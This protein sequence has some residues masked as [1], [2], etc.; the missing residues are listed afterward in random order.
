MTDSILDVTTGVTYA[1]VSDAIAL[2]G[3]GDLIQIPAGTYAEDFPKIR[4]D[5]TLEGVGGLAH[6]EPV[7][8]QPPSN[9]EAI[10]VTDAN[11]TLEKLELSGATV[12]DGNGA[13]VREETGNLTVV[14]SW[15]HDNQDGILTSGS[16]AGA[17]LTI[18]KTE[19]S[20]N[21]AGDGKT[22]N[23]YVGQIA[24]LDIT[25]SYFTAANG[26]HEI[27]SRADTTIIED[28]RIQDG[29]TADTSYSVDLPNGGV[30]T[31][32]NNV[33]EKGPNSPDDAIIHYGGEVSTVDAGSSLVISNNTVINDKGAAP[34]VF[35][36]AVFA[37]GGTI[38]APSISG[39]TF[40]GLTADQLLA[41]PDFGDTQSGAPYAATNNFLPIGDEPALDTSP[42][43]IPCFRAGTR[44]A[45]AGGPVAVEALRA[46]DRVLS[47]FG[48]SV[49]VVWI[50][51]RHIDCRRHPRPEA[52]LPV[53]IR[54]GAFG[55]GLPHGDLWLSPE[56]SEHVDD[57]LI[58]IRCLVNGDSIRQEPVEVVTYCH[59]EL[60]AHD[61]IF[62]QGLPAE[63]YLDTGYRGAFA[64]G[65][66]LRAVPDDYAQR[67]WAAEGCAPHI[68]HGPIHARVLARLRAMAA[69]LG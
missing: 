61:V 51:Y 44:I 5:L 4:H 67:V 49:P 40:Y 57:V 35:D 8:G 69:G 41:G 14:N 25:D 34:F 45:T 2:S 53:R 13:G 56:H 28:S 52:V 30:A 38:V 58:P 43:F 36:Q 42:P 16:L 19:F 29:P 9:G 63:S 24:T 3:S 31:I 17:V 65:G 23:L 32:E 60:P 39:N 22:H 55:A 50:G 10:L 68:T 66:P 6:L 11:V 27:K 7:A 48:G 37:T 12:S 47:A 59:V 62:A 18:S 26:G 21:G 54:A 20:D 64:N 46:G 33:I 1:T 15:I